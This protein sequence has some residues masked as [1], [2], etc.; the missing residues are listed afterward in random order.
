MNFKDYRV[1][2]RH[3]L[4]KVNIE[5]VQVTES[6]VMVSANRKLVAT[7]GIVVGIPTMFDEDEEVVEIGETIIYHE[8]SGLQVPNETEHLIL[9][10]ED[11]MLVKE[12]KKGEKIIL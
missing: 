3:I 10:N 4:I 11:I 9:L 8:H 7:S 6:G 1:P 5:S 12:N 2:K